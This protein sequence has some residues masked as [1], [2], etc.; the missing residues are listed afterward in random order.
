VEYA[1]RYLDA[2]ALLG[3]IITGLLQTLP[4]LHLLRRV[5]EGGHVELLVQPLYREGED[6]PVAVA[7][8]GGEELVP[9]HGARGP[10]VLLYIAPQ[11][12]EI[13]FEK[14]EQV[15]QPAV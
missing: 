4:L 9:Y 7:D 15:A 1:A 6:H 3:L 5:G 10:V 8:G 13:G 12:G 2:P 11:I 14:V